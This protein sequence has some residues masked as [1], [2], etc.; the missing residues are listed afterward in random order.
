MTT[1]KVWLTSCW[2]LHNLILDQRPAWPGSVVA[3]IVE[4]NG[5]QK[6]AIG[7]LRTDQDRRSGKSVSSGGSANH[8]NALTFPHIPTTRRW[9]RCFEMI[10]AQAVNRFPALEVTREPQFAPKPEVHRYPL[11]C[12]GP[13]ADRVDFF[14]YP[15]ANIRGPFSPLKWRGVM[16]GLITWIVQ[17]ALR[18]QI[19]HSTKFITEQQVLAAEVSI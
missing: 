16:D 3:N 13:Q 19:S 14:V 5:Q 4:S 18:Q 6:L 17:I 8:T 7:S 10:M 12:G 1:V 11:S 15:A 2:I 9:L